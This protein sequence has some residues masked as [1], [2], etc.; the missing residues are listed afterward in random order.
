M[1]FSPK[2]ILTACLAL[3]CMITCLG[4]TTTLAFD[5]GYKSADEYTSQVT[6]TMTSETQVDWYKFTITEDEVPTEYDISLKI[7]SDGVYNFDL[8]YAED[9]AS[10][11]KVV[12]NETI[13]SGTRKRMMSGVFYNPGV[14]YVRVYVQ[15]GLS[16][17]TYRL[18]VS[19]EKNISYS[20]TLPK[21]SNKEDHADWS[22][23]AEILG[24]Y[25]FD[26]YIKYATNDRTYLNAYTFINSNYESDSKAGSTTELKATPEQTAIAADY[27]FSGDLMTNPKFMVE[28]DKI[29]TIDELMYSIAALKRPIIFYCENEQAV[30]F[31]FDAYKRYVILRAVNIGENTI[32][33]FNPADNGEE[34][35][36]YTEFLANGVYLSNKSMPYT[37]TNIVEVNV[38]RPVQAIYD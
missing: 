37:G 4:T 23:C 3:T 18:S 7:P 1:K 8:R 12:S 21:I 11:P 30:E 26:N 13:V 20:L 6:S 35:V 38:P 32:T 31:G 17:E 16:D 14:Y 27:I 34:T 15:N 36:S 33:Y 5:N 19:Y 29:Y 9:S 25:T 10:R 28:N 24:K 2:R 22:V